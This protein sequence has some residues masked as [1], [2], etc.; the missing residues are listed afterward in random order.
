[1]PTKI[2]RFIFVYYSFTY[3]TVLSLRSWFGVMRTE[4]RKEEREKGR[5]EGDGDTDKRTH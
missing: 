1:M 3:C 2:K 5:K 4:G